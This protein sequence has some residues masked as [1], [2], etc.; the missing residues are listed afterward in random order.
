MKKVDTVIIGSGISGLAMAKSCKDYGIDYM[1]LERTE[2]FGGLW[3]FRPDQNYGVTTFTCINVSKQNYSFSDFPPPTEYPDYCHH[4]RLRAYLKSYVEHH[5]LEDKMVFKKQVNL[6]EKGDNGTWVLH[7][8]NVELSNGKWQQVGEEEMIHA[9]NVAICSGHHVDANHV[10]FNKQDQ[11]KHHLIHS[12][13]YKN[14]NHNNIKNQ[15]VLVVGIGN[16]AVDTAVNLVDL[17][18][19]RVTISSRSGAWIYP[20]YMFGLP[21]DQFASRAFLKWVP[22]GFANWFTELVVKQLQGDPKWWGLNPKNRILSSQP[23]VSPTLIHH[24][25]RGN[26][27]IRQNISSFTENG[28]IFKDGQRD[29]FDS[30]IMCTGFKV[31]CPF[32]APELKS[33]AFGNAKSKNSVNLYKQVFL[34]SAG[35]SLAFIGFAQPASGGLL[36]ISEMQ[37]RWFCEHIVGHLQLPPAE[38]M[39]AE[40]QGRNKAQMT[41]YSGSDRHTIQTDPLLY[42]DDIGAEFGA[43]PTLLSNPSLAIKLLFSSAGAAQYRL[44]GPHSWPG[45]AQEVDKLTVPG[46]IRGILWL[47]LS[48]MVSIA[49]VAAMKTL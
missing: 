25:Q 38:Q 19:N 43:R 3:T 32:L 15:N 9:K 41:T 35:N 20:N 4:T 11:Y 40:L 39:E 18:A 22:T 49:A 37:S 26:I 28:V 48:L 8:S 6:L 10:K 27:K 44:Q 45:A 31:D 29:D 21:T 33:A 42:C 13:K 47:V 30:V 24:L 7:V 2:T 12:E 23:T 34:P 16:S 36:Q 5:S 1:I 17:G 14:A 46:M